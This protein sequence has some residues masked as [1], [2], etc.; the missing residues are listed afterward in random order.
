M[1]NDDFARKLGENIQIVRKRLKLTQEHLADKA[2][3]SRMALVNYEGGRRTPPVDSCLK[4]ANALGVTIDELVN[5]DMKAKY[6]KQYTATFS[7][8]QLSTEDKKGMAHRIKKLGGTDVKL[9]EL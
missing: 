1:R 8:I 3:I 4:I 5:T 7:C 2:K 9:E 6:Q